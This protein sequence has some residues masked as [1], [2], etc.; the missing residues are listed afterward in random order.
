MDYLHNYEVPDDFWKL[1]TVIHDFEWRYIDHVYE[2]EIK[3]A[4][5]RAYYFWFDKALRLFVPVEQL[6][7]ELEHEMLELEA[8]EERN[9]EN[10]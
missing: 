7:I 3:P 1:L 2:T 9:Y 10:W 6:T 8:Q 5:D 4:E